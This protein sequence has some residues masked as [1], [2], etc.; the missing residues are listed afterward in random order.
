MFKH[1][2]VIAKRGR[3]DYLNICLQYLYDAITPEHDVMI[4]IVCDDDVMEATMPKECV[5]S[6]IKMDP[7]EKFCKSRLLNR[8]LL[9]MRS[10]FDFVSIVDL[11]ILYNPKFFDEISKLD[12]NTYFI[13]SGYKM[14]SHASPDVIMSI[15][16]FNDLSTFID[17]SVQHENHRKLYPSQ[18]TLSKSL[19]N[20]LVTILD[21]GGK[22]YNEQFLS[23][24]GEDSALSIFSRYCEEVGILKKVYSHDMWYHIWHDREC[25][26]IDFDKDQYNNNLNLLK[27]LNSENQRKVMEYSSCQIKS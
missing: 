10:D 19:Y 4:Y 13:S 9:E 16:G 11:D 14:V 6:F 8:G 21:N 2:I 18:I 12:D 1:N 25:D 26:K 15:S 3:S 17:P 5:L 23:W 27:K 20:K 24:G 22:L 7:Q